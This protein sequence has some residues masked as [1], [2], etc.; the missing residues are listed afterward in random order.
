MPFLIFQIDTELLF[1]VQVSLLR[2]ILCV[3]SVD[4]KTLRQFSLHV[5]KILEM[6]KTMYK[7]IEGC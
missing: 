4:I 7:E 3:I 5:Q 6:G 1:H 2:D